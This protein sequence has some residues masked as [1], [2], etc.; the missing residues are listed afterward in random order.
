I[1]RSGANQFFGTL[2]YEFRSQSLVGDS[3]DRNSDTTGQL[4]NPSRPISSFDEKQFGMSLGGP[5][6]K[7]KAFFFVNADLTRN[8][9]PT[10]FS[11]DGSSGQ[12]FIVPQSDL[13]TVL[14]VLKNQYGYDPSAGKGNA[15]GEFVRDTPSNKIFA[16]LD[17]NLSD[18]HR[19]TIRNNL[20]KP[21]T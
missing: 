12:R 14:S 13:D 17:F 19:L 10:G 21:R 6:V 3:A 8:H 9:T 20:T 1:T 5:I 15:L 2:Y 18:K 16:R 11:G 7:N 4:V